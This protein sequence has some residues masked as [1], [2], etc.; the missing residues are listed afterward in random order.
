MNILITGARSG[1]AYKVIEKIKDKDYN[2]YVTV[3]TL[4][5]LKRVKELYKDYKNITCFKLDLLNKDDIDSINNLDID[6]L[7]LNASIGYGGSIASIDIDKIYENYEVNVFS[8]IK[9]IQIVLNKMILKNSGIIIIT[10]SLAGVI[11]ISFLGSYCSSKSSLNMIARILKKELKLISNIKVK[12]ILPGMY[13]TGFNQVMLNNKYDCKF[14][15]GIFKDELKLIKFKENLLF[16]LLEK[17]SLDSIVN[18]I[19]KAIISDNSKFIYYSPVSQ[20]II[21]KI[22]QL[23]SWYILFI[24]I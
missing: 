16:N 7:Y 13:H 12:L 8:N 3:R 24:L 1:I 10:G 4:S 21:S 15:N 14:N 9:L 18:K 5:Q 17:K 19:Y 6:I 20:Y 11:P 23:F 22:Y 2:I